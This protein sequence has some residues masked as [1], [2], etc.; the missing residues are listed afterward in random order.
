MEIIY[1]VAIFIAPG[2]ICRSLRN[3]FVK[4]KHRYENV[5]DY[6]F[7]IVIDSIVV[8]CICVTVLN[9]FKA[10]LQNL[11]QFVEYITIFRN[12]IRYILI[13][14]LF[15][16]IWTV[17]R[18]YILKCM[19]FVKNK[20]IEQSS[21][22]T[23]DDHTTAWDALMAEEKF[24]DSWKVVSLYK[25]EHY[26]TSGFVEGYTSTNSEEFEIVL[27]L[28]KETEERLKNAPE[29]F[30]TENDYYNVKTGLRV[31]IYDPKKIQE[32]WS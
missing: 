21:G 19:L 13:V 18:K 17:S 32:H 22:I 28:T 29:I 5:Y 10:E 15:S 20:I 26:I 23:H 2:M 31:I 25:D 30:Y 27:Q 7:D 16:I 4:E 14:L 1:L 12:S 6:L 8:N 24:K 9:L 11:N 3:Y